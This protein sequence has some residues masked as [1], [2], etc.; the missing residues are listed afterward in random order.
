MT[1]AGLSFAVTQAGLSFH[2]HRLGG[3]G[4]D[5][6]PVRLCPGKLQANQAFSITPTNGYAISGVTVDGASAGAFSSYTFNNVTTNHTIS[7]S[8]TATTS[9]T[10]SLTLAKTGPGTGSVTTSPSG[11]TFASGTSVTLTA[12]ASAGSTFAGWSGACTGTSGTCQVIMNGNMSVGAAF[13]SSSSSDTVSTSVQDP[14]GATT[15]EASTNGGPEEVEEAGR[16]LLHRDRGLWLLPRSSRSCA[17]VLQGQFPPHEQTREGLRLLVLRYV[18]SLCRRHT[19][20]RTPQDGCAH[21][22][23]PLHRIRLSVPGCRTR[24]HSAHGR[25]FS[26]RPRVGRE[27][28]FGAPRCG[29]EAFV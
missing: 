8:F 21:R 23:P 15:S 5:H 11:T 4:R 3:D 27:E 19:A 6:I 18:A 1:I 26:C 20:E 29:G 10:Y 22:P 2:H 24:A 13:S 17:Q 9:N 14:A 25:C 16:G 12:A 7:A 28:A